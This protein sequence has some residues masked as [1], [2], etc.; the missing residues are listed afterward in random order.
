MYS[1]NILK[2]CV[3]LIYLHLKKNFGGFSSLFLVFSH[4][5]FVFSH[6]L[7]Y[8]LTIYGIFSPF[9]VFSHNFRYFLKIFSI[10]KQFLVFHCHFW[11][12]SP[13]FIFLTVY[14]IFSQFVVFSHHFWYFLT[15]FG[16]FSHFWHFLAIFGIFSTLFGIFVGGWNGKRR[17][18]RSWTAATDS[19][20]HPTPAKDDFRTSSSIQN[21]K[22]RRLSLL[23]VVVTKQQSVTANIWREPVICEPPRIIFLSCIWWY[24]S[25]WYQ[26]INYLV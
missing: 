10:F 3:V 21:S 8:F 24:D 2:Y 20:S 16:I 17:T 14:G 25:R 4:L 9:S 13:F 11:Y 22:Q 23:V 26:R 18:R 7:G 19:T 5:F 1:Y 6:H 15:I 12:L